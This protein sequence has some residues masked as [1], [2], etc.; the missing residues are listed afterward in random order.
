[1]SN[2][3]TL[4]LPKGR[5]LTQTAEIFARAGV[6]LGPVLSASRQLRHEL[7]DAGLVVLSVR[8]SDVPTYVEYG[9]ADIGVTGKDVLEEAAR[10]LYEMLDLGIGRCRM[11]VAAPAGTEAAPSALRVATKYPNVARRH[12]LR[13]GVPVD[14]VKLVGSVELAVLCGLADRIG[15][16]VVSG[17]TLRLNRLTE[18]E[19]VFEVTARL[20]VNRASLKT[21]RRAVDGLIGRLA[22]A[23]ER[24]A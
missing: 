7:P 22:D 20:V 23:L 4:A 21:R 13:R 12:F 9:V 11:V 5:L 10:D 24:D 2:T 3:L 17:E 6:D 19:D 1:M 8:A 16:I 18:V 15:D 14:I